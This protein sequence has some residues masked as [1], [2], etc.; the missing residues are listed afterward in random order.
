M[1]TSHSCRCHVHDAHKEHF[2]CP[3]TLSPLSY[4]APKWKAISRHAAECVEMN[5][6]TNNKRY[7]NRKNQ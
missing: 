5:E 3:R 7:E 2:L 6:L 1:N 4:V